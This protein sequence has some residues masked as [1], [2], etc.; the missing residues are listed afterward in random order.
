MATTS[1]KDNTP[2]VATFRMRGISVAVYA[3]QVEKSPVPMYKVSI[4][5]TYVQKGEFKTVTS[6]LRDDLPVAEHLFRQAWLRIIELEQQDRQ[7]LKD[8]EEDGESSSDE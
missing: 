2:P 4:K 7:S 1:S 5:R 8:H 6:L 3:N